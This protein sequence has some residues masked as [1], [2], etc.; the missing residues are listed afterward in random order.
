[1]QYYYSQ[2]YTIKGYGKA[3]FYVLDDEEKIRLSDK[4]D[5]LEK[6]IKI[7]PLHK[8][9]NKYDRQ[10]LVFLK[11]MTQYT[12]YPESEA[13]DATEQQI[14]TIVNK[15][16]LKV[17]GIWL[18]EFLNWMKLFK[19]DRPMDGHDIKAHMDKKRKRIKLLKREGLL[20]EDFIEP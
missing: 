9:F 6:D 5:K 18:G 20:P 3:L 19:D 10:A 17:Y 13:I 4:I 12:Y 2:N 8:R 16:L 14:D 15:L 11:R 7:N 1:M